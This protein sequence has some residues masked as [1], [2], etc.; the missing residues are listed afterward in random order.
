LKKY[1]QKLGEISEAEA[2]KEGFNS[3]E[4]FKE[5]WIKII[6]Q[7]NPSLEV[8][9]YE[10]KLDKPPKNTTLQKWTKNP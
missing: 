5:A 1:S 9:A 8:V 10:F 2:R 7:W 4:E 3:L 6:G